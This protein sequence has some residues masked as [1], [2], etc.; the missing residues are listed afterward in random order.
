MRIGSGWTVRRRRGERA[1]IRADEEDL[2]AAHHDIGLAD[3]RA[4]ARIAFTSQPASAIRLVA[5]LDEVVVK[6]L[7]V[8]DDGHNQNRGRSPI[9]H[10]ED[11]ALRDR[12]ALGVPDV[13]AREAIEAYPSFLP[14]CAAPRC[15]SAIQ[16]VR[17]PRDREP[18]RLRSRSPRITIIGRARGSTCA[19]SP[20]RSALRRRMALR[21]ARERACASSSRCNTSSRAARSAG[22]SRRFSTGSPIRW[23]M[24]SSGVRRRFMN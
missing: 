3:R 22:C 14:W 20:G 9:L 11:C 2:S 10:E 21:A 19:S 8:L 18:R 24:P 7:S 5:L 17:G 6:G 23:S 16:A 4:P 12:R 1:D 15:T 13:R